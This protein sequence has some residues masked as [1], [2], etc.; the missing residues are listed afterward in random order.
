M[1]MAASVQTA[2]PN[3]KPGFIGAMKEVYNEFSDDDVMTQGAAIAFYSGL[4]MAPMLTIAVW[5]M[6]IFVGDEAKKQ[7]VNA[8]SQVI[9]AQAA[10]PIRQMLDP[11]SE[12]AQSG[13]TI[14]GIV[15]L[16]LLAFSASGVFG[17]LQSA[18]N[19]IWDVKA[20]PKSSIWGFVNKR[21]LSLGMLMSILFLLM[22]SLVVSTVLQGFTG[23][24]GEDSKGWLWTILSIVIS[25]GLFTL[26]FAMLFKYV[27]DAKISW[28][29]VWIGGFISA[30]LFTIGKFGLAMYLGRGSYENSYGAAIGSFV[31][32]L[33]WVY[34]SAIIVL[35]G[36]EATEVYARRNGHAVEPSEHA[37]R[38]IAHEEEVG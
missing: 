8:F 7:L 26:M 21:L 18:L 16:I 27:P 3:P 19:T 30:V 28:R 22:T 12:Q 31:A 33:V 4:A 17:Q 9:G 38:V 5:A 25:L 1:S 14:A 10:E 2:D 35:I 32:L 36:G 37:V 34:Y 15:S 23:T 20:K 24:R 29:A 11:A 13:M 6:Q